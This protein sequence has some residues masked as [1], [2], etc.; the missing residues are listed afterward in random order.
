MIR[1]PHTE[2]I[3]TPEQVLS[4]RDASRHQIESWPNDIPA[5]TAEAGSLPTYTQMGQVYTERMLADDLDPRFR[6]SG[7]T[8][9]LAIIPRFLYAGAAKA[10]R[11]GYDIDEL[12]N[13][14]YNIGTLESLSNLTIDDNDVVVALEM[15]LGLRPGGIKTVDQSLDHYTFYPENGLSFTNFDRARRIAHLDAY[16]RHGKLYEFR[17]ELESRCEGQRTGVLAIAYRAM[18]L[19]SLSDS[20]LFQATLESAAE[21]TILQP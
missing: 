9:G 5:Y 13:G 2:R 1:P 12:K 4:F 6:S 3:I 18:L 19:I 14:M 11:L 20:N 7:S 16:I 15:E 21:P 8:G 17:T 10:A